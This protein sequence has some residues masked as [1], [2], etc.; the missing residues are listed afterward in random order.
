MPRYRVSC[1]QVVRLAVALAV[2][3]SL[4]PVP[5]ACAQ[6]GFQQAVGG[7]SV[8]AQGVLSNSEKDHNGLRQMLLDNLQAVPGLLNEPAKL[9]KI[10][11]RGIE[12]ALAELVATQGRLPDEL[13]YLAGL[14]RIEY[15]M[16]DREHN[17]IVLAGYSEGWKVDARGNMI[18]VTTGRPI[19]QLDDLLIALRTAAAA[20][21][22]G[23]T[24]SIDP[25]SEG[26]ARV[27]EVADML[28]VPNADPNFVGKE[29]ERLLG[30]QDI[31]F[32]GVPPESRFAH[33]LLAA[34][35][36]MKRIA[37]A[38][39]P[40]PVKG[41]ASYLNMI[42]ATTKAGLQNLLPRWWLTTNYDPLL[43][44]DEG[45]VWQIRGQGVKAMS[46]DDFLAADGSRKHTGKASPA[47]QKWAD[48]MTKK[49]VDLSLREP[50]FGELRNC[51]DL[52]V[53]AALIVKEDLPGKADLKLPTMLS[54]ES[55]PTHEYKVPR[56]V[57]SKASFVQ[58]TNG[59]LLSVS[60]GVQIN[61]WGEASRKEVSTDL[62]RAREQL[63]EGRGKRWWWN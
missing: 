35:Y 36:R 18:G 39:D 13:R 37:M 6:I 52:A 8:N 12:A 14:Q 47:A 9:R 45:L 56:H 38:F 5:A 31:S 59:F 57:D 32:H 63:N 54:A 49:Y 41:L 17:D 44:D 50:I 24:C 25:T 4:L 28:S 20:A 53:V 58:A 60:G 40:P 30:P 26:L 10:S 2:G 34:D 29:V 16:V 51:I 11:L 42:K 55:Y 22:G 19:M 15:V 23:I 43:T 7:I 48:Q 62:A 1:A 3:F 27:R 61:S 21:H 46:E 33:V